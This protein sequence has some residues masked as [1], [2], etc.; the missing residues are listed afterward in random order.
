MTQDLEE[1]RLA[2]AVPEF[3]CVPDYREQAA[4]ELGWL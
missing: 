1:W 2:N 3:Q 4:D